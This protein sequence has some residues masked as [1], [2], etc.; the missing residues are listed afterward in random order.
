MFSPHRNYFSVQRLQLL[1]TS[2][3]VRP[4]RRLPSYCSQNRTASNCCLILPRI[5]EFLMLSSP[6]RIPKPL[7]GT[8]LFFFHYS[9]L[10]FRVI[11]LFKNSNFY[12]K[13]KWKK[14]SCLYLGGGGPE[15]GKGHLFLWFFQVMKVMPMSYE[16]LKRQ[17]WFLDTFVNVVW[18]SAW[19]SF[20][21]I[22]N[23]SIRS[24]I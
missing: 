6:T 13:T 2:F 24:S 12:L 8:P 19:F 15:E 1:V 14:Y 21:R 9:W 3:N 20:C 16:S 4:D 10:C 23:S 5:F 22:F 18:I 11:N 17:W 7:K